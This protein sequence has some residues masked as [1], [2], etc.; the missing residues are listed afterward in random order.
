MGPNIHK[1]IAHKVSLLLIPPGSQSGIAQIADALL[2]PGGL[3]TV[4]REATVWVEAA[5]AAVRAAPDNTYADAEAIAGEILR[6]V[7]ERLAKQKG[8][9]RR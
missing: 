5:L 2:T 7:D 1:L 3:L 4:T 8:E 6:R 9:A